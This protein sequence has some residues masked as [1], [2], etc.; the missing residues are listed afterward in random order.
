MCISI[1]TTVYAESVAILCGPVA[2]GIGLLLCPSSDNVVRLTSRLKCQPAWS[3]GWAK[4]GQR[5]A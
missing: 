3:K 2:H 4:V 1:D 5:F